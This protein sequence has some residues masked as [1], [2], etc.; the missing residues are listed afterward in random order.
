MGRAVIVAAGVAACG[1]GAVEPGAA[2][3][4]PASEPVRVVA[5]AAEA[6][7]PGAFA[8]LEARLRA[9]ADSVDAALRRVRTL[10][11][12][13]QGGLRRDVNDPQTARA[14]ALGVRPGDRYEEAAAAGRL[15]RLADTTSL[16]V[17]RKLDFSVPYTTPGAEAMLA[18]L[19]SRFHAALDSLGVPRYRLDITS[20]LRTP[21]KQAALRRANANAADGVSAHEFG[22]TVDIAYRSF[23]PP[24][25]RAAEPGLHP[26]LADSARV[27]RDSLLTETARLRA[28]EL[29]A[30]LGRVLLEMRAEGKLMVMMER[31]QTVYH[32]T[33]AR[34]FPGHRPVP[35]LREGGADAP[36]RAMER[37]DAER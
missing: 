25:A 18:E 2:A 26:A 1:G 28:A 12:A 20:V 27:L 33:V 15:V 34:R 31:R 22:T 13:E 35:P 24:V 32:M 9:E 7:D 4:N 36:P 29:Q 37:A 23:A 8:E 19:G 10:S 6:P 21:E 11:G 3:G 14:R 30:V 5:A 17:V 16:W